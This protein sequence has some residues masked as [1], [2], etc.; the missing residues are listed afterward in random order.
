MQ[1][2]ASARSALQ[3]AILDRD[4]GLAGHHAGFVARALVSHTFWW[5]EPDKGHAYLPAVLAAAA[6]T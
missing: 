3:A 5:L 2:M 1:K 4:Q 6:A